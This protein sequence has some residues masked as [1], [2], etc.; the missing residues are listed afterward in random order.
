MAQAK[1]VLG[2]TPIQQVITS[3]VHAVGSTLYILRNFKLKN[4]DNSNLHTLMLSFSKLKGG[5][6]AIRAGAIKYLEKEVLGLE[7][8]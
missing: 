3:L 8:K 7:I 5:E 6:L 2:N 1:E 4:I